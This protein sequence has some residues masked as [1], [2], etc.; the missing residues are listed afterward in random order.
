MSLKIFNDLTCRD[1][2]TRSNYEKDHFV[3]ANIIV[4]QASQ[5]LPDNYH[6]LL[7]PR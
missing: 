1:M 5:Q 4:I 7:S 2:D 3:N 6:R